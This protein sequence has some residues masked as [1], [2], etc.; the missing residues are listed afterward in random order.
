MTRPTQEQRGPA[1][2][3][4]ACLLALAL[5]VPGRP[6]AGTAAEPVE[7]L[8]RAMRPHLE[9]QAS[10]LNRQGVRLYRQGR[11]A[12]ATRLLEQALAL[13]QW[14]YPP[15]EYPHGHRDLALSLQHLG[16]VLKI[17]AQYRRALPLC[18]QALAMDQALYPAGHPA[19]GI[20]LNN[21]GTLLYQQGEF[22]RALAG[23][24]GPAFDKVVRL[25]AAA[26]GETGPG[27]KAPVKLWAGFV[28]S[29]AGR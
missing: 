16:L 14:L 19:M 2:W 10:A 22:Q 7:D 25:P 28:L 8:S 15:S 5:G 29:G 23:E 6:A 26:P 17:Q 4:A 21:L 12:E 3:P 9:R 24:R 13:R 27:G 1:G 11:H 18:Q 20:T